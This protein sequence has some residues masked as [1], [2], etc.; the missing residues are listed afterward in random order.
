MRASFL[1][2]GAAL[3]GKERRVFSVPADP[4]AKSARQ[5][6]ARSPNCAYGCYN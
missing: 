6:R 1:P 5:V 3:F 2:G 4:R